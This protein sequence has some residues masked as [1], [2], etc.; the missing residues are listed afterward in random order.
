MFTRF[1]QILHFSGG[2]R[3]KKI[4]WTN[5]LWENK[6]LSTPLLW[7]WIVSI[8]RMW[9]V[10]WK[11]VGSLISFLCF[12]I[13]KS[14][15]CCCA[16][17]IPCTSSFYG[18]VNTVL[19]CSVL[20]H[21][22]GPQ[23]MK[24]RNEGMNHDV[25]TWTFQFGC[26]PWF[27][28]KRMWFF[29]IPCFFL[30]F[31]VR[32]PDWFRCC[33]K[34]KDINRSIVTAPEHPGFVEICVASSSAPSV[35]RDLHGFLQRK[36]EEFRENLYLE[37]QPTSLKWNHPIETSIGKWLA[38][39]FQVYI[40]KSSTFF[41]IRFTFEVTNP[42][43]FASGNEIS[44]YFTGI[45]LRHYKDPVMNQDLMEWHFFSTVLCWVVFF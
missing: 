44:A 5:I 24:Y 37:S 22:A 43:W 33:E 32:H 11:G 12:W 18:L 28:K 36:G 14:S 40:Q 39:G 7:V 23:V 9:T 31:F 10:C 3:Q 16:D 45:V 41:S 42:P 35:E 17:R 25:Y 21:H 30:F 1:P 6:L 20:L 15:G 19:P 13:R 26:L 4:T 29:T 8:S 27:P 2:V 38:L 34:H